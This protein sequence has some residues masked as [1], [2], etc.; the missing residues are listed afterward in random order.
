MP[1]HFDC[2]TCQRMKTT[3]LAGY[4]AFSALSVLLGCGG[5]SLGPNGGG[6]AGGTSAATAGTGGNGGG[7]TSDGGRDDGQPSFD[8][9][10]I[11]PCEG[12]AARVRASLRVPTPPP[13]NQAIPPPLDLAG[14][15]SGVSRD[16]AGLH[17]AIRDQS[18]AE[19]VLSI[20][21]LGTIDSWEAS[22]QEIVGR[23]VTLKARYARRF[24]LDVS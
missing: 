2:T 15:V 23:Q 19:W 5:A 16:D 17:I 21:P 1:R 13:A 3:S 10:V 4:F 12:P 11:P 6:G 8:S 18:D 14:T 9:N 7:P 22:A 20:Q 24:Q